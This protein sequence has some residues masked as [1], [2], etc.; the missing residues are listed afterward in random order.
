MSVI[1]DTPKPI[2]DFLAPELRS[3]SARLDALDAKVSDQHQQTMAA[4]AN[5]AKYQ[6]VL[7]RVAKLESRISQ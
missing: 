3:I 2:Q 6:A 4:I 5:L 1:E 7:E